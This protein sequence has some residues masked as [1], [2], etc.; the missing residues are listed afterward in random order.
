MTEDA[1]YAV[2]NFMKI[3]LL[4]VVVTSTLFL[5][6]CISTQTGM[7][8][9]EE[10]KQTEKIGTVEDEFYSFHLLHMYNKTTIQRKAYR[11]L[12]KKAEKKYPGNIDVVNIAIE[13]SFSIFTYVITP[14]TYFLT[15]LQTVMATGDVILSSVTS[16]AASQIDKMAAQIA[17]TFKG[18]QNITVAVL[19]FSNV[20]GKQSVLGAYLADQTTNYLFKNSKL[21]IVERTQISKVITELEFGQTGL[22]SEE[23]A[24]KIGQ[25]LGA[26]SVVLGSITKIGGKGKKTSVTIKIVD[27]KTGALLSSG[28]MEISGDEYLEMYDQVLKK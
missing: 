1:K 7:L 13:G 17:K 2:K 14:C 28:T 9:P 4:T 21:K 6:A 3:G 5:N 12:K 11:N 16:D 26:N 23:S 25:M 19:D 10:M 15:N 20:D 27:T 22:I 24:I 8:S 18:N